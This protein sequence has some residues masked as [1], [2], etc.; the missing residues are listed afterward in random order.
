MIESALKVIL[1]GAGAMCRARSRW[2]PKDWEIVAVADRKKELQGQFLFE[3]YE[4]ISPETIPDCKFDLVVMMVHPRYKREVRSDLNRM[5]IAPWRIV[6]GDKY[7]SEWDTAM[8]Y[9]E[10][11]KKK[12]KILDCQYRFED[13]SQHK[14]KLLYVLIGYKEFLWEDV[15]PR[16]NRF[17]P[18]DIDVCL[19][20]GGLYSERL[21]EIALE[22]QWSY[23]STDVNDVTVSQNLVMTIFKDAG[24]IYKMDEDI[25]ITDHAFQKMEELYK[26][27]EREG[28]LSIGYI[29]PVIPMH[30]SAYV[31]LEEFGLKEKYKKHFQRNLVYGGDLSSPDIRVNPEFPKWF[32]S[33]GPVDQLNR[34]AETRGERYTLTTLRYAIC[35]ILFSREFFEEMGGFEVDEMDSYGSGWNGDE[36][37]IM[38]YCSVSGKMGVI[39]LNTVCGHFCY[40]AQEEEMRRFRA[41]HP[42]LFEMR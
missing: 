1:Y 9:L 28:E 15:L 6:D 25:Y 21:S 30:S 36:A 14:D 38:K 20:S 33:Q 27:L 22:Y 37:Q 18:E 19:V 32:W 10:V 35:F 34:D 29:G 42:E 8:Y 11:S 39:A 7:M 40:Y 5:G 26:R 12:R 4:I 41:E 13:R 31:F 3:K 23:L 16:L 17:C 2:I 24:M